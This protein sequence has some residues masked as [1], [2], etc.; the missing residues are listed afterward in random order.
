MPPGDR[1]RQVSPLAAFHTG[2]LGE[3][4]PRPT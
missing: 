1:D 4:V 3:R 2:V